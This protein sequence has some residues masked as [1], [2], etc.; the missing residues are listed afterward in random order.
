MTSEA[1]RRRLGQGI[2][3]E[4]TPRWTGAKG[5]AAVWRTASKARNS[6]FDRQAASMMG[7]SAQRT[8]SRG[9]QQSVCRFFAAAGGRGGGSIV[10]LSLSRSM[11]TSIG[12]AVPLC[13]KAGLPSG[14]L[15]TDFRHP[16]SPGR[17]RGG[18][19]EIDHGAPGSFSLRGQVFVIPGPSGEGWGRTDEHRR[20]A[21]HVSKERGASTYAWSRNLMGAGKLKPGGRGRAAFSQILALSSREGETR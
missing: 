21:L 17:R 15:R 9:R 11:F 12:E 2:K 13:R 6:R 7:A 8:L 4:A 5:P 1:G 14:F 18:S 19:A 3:A 20:G 16:V 10:R